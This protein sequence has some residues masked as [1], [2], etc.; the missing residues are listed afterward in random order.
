MPTLNSPKTGVL[1]RL[2][3]LSISFVYPTVILAAAGLW[4]LL[5]LLIWHADRIQNKII[6]NKEL[7][8][9]SIVAARDL[10]QQPSA[11]AV[12]NIN[13]DIP[14]TLNDIPFNLLQGTAYSGSTV[15]YREPAGVVSAYISQVNDDLDKLQTS[16]KNIFVI[17][18][19]IIIVALFICVY[20]F[21]FA[22]NKVLNPLIQLTRQAEQIAEGDYTIRNQLD[23]KNEVGV[24]ASAMNQM[25]ER[26]IDD[27]NKQKHMQGELRLSEES[28]RNT[29]ENA[30]IGMAIVSSDGK[31]LQVNRSQCDI[32]GYTRSELLNLTFMDITYPD[33]KEQS[34]DYLYKLLSGA[35]KTFK[36]EKRYIRKDGRVIWVM[37]HVSIVYSITSKDVNFISQIQDITESKENE[38]RLADLNE[39]MSI[40]LHELKQHENEL[41][42]I[43]KTN[44]MLQTCKESKEA[45]SIISLTS[46]GLFPELSGGLAIY[47]DSNK[48]LETVEHWGNSPILKSY[49]APDECWAIRGGH[50]HHVINPGK[51]ILCNHFTSPIT[52]GYIDL[53][54]VVQSEMIGVFHLYAPPG[55]LITPNQQQLAA[56]FSEVIKLSLANIKLREALH[57]QAIRDPLTG[58][59][60]RRYLNETLP[61]ELQL[62]IRE[63]RQLCV[64]MLDLDFFK[65]FNDNYGHEAG[66]EVLRYIG[67]LLRNRFRGSDIACRFGG[68]E[69]VVV[70]LDSEL[71]KVVERLQ[72]IREEVKKAA[73]TY[74]D[75][76]LPPITV[77]IGVAKA[78]EHGMTAEDLIHAADIALYAAKQA[79]RDRLE[80]YHQLSVVNRKNNNSV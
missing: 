58:L 56:T 40:A 64:A 50:I 18:Q 43:N 47:N 62:I 79:G 77:S 19:L 34:R 35:I 22:R 69:F 55:Y 17:L 30:P 67:T 26:L 73:L 78:P 71:P 8:Y 32:T 66:D 75:R 3:N 46:Q 23:L 45:Y 10:K 60:N 70:L 28:F 20:A 25:S 53:P 12:P 51:D 63:N 21:V 48:S 24:L 15:N 74:H 39:N 16:L 41:I 4:I 44:D 36:M 29:M 57:E 9:A 52:S 2:G 6:I 13:S 7:R 33:D 76:T 59:F 80:I 42:L 68:E 38:K 54:L 65:R 1:S 11:F 61:R 72:Q 31:Y 5:Y 14:G 27:I 37:L 49:F